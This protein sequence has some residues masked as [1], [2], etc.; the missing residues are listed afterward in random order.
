MQSLISHMFSHSC[1]HTLTISPTHTN[2][3]NIQWSPTFF[4]LLLVFVNLRTWCTHLDHRPLAVSRH[5][6]LSQLHLYYT[7]THT[8]TKIFPSLLYC[9]PL[10]SSHLILTLTS[11]PLTA[12]SSVQ[13]LHLPHGLSCLIL[14]VIPSSFPFIFTSLLPSFLSS[15]A[16]G[17]DLSDRRCQPPLPGS[18]AHTQPIS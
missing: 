15:R 14:S 12:T 2:T 6:R 5:Q 8:Y 13:D 4:C 16:V 18:N 17:A 7:H 10:S 3:H 1:L 9:P 11:P